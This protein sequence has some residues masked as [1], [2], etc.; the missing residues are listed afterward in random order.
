MGYAQSI[1]TGFG[2]GALGRREFGMFF[3]GP[4]SVGLKPDRDAKS[5]RGPTARG[6]GGG[7]LLGHFAVLAFGRDVDRSDTDRSLSVHLVPHCAGHG[8]DE[9]SLHSG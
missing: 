9:Q 8:G 2:Y 6:P 7:S 3:E 5:H 4:G 1:F